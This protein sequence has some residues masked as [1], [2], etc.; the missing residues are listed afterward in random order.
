MRACRFIICAGMWV[1]NVVIHKCG[2]DSTGWYLLFV[3]VP[4]AS[5]YYKSQRVLRK[6]ARCLYHFGMIHLSRH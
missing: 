2:K 3:P 4:Y 6:L 1:I 5:T